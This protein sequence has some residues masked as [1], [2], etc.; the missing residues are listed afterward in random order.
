[1]NINNNIKDRST[2]LFIRK[3][4]KLRIKRVEVLEDINFLTRCLKKNVI[5]KFVNIKSSVH[6]SRSSRAL[7]TAKRQWIK[8]ELKTK[9]GMLDKINWK[10]YNDH[11]ELYSIY[12]PCSYL[13]DIELAKIEEICNVIKKEKKRKLKNKFE[14]L[15]RRREELHKDQNPGVENINIVHNLSKVFFSKE[16]LELLNKGLKHKTVPKKPPLDEIIVNIE[17]G[18]ERFE[19]GKEE[20]AAI[21]SEIREVIKSY[22]IPYKNDGDMKVIKELQEKGKEVYYT[23]PDKGKGVVIMDKEDYEKKMNIAL[24][25]GPYELT[26]DGRWKD[27]S[28]LSKLQND[29]QKTLKRIVEEHNFNKFI[30]S[31]LLVSNPKLPIVYGCPKIHKQGYPMRI[32]CSS[33]NEP[34]S[35]IGEYLIKELN[36]F[37][38]R[39]VFS[40]QNSQQFVERIVNQKILEDEVMISFDVV[41][42]FPSIPKEVIKEQMIQF[43][44]Q[45]ELEE[46][47]K[48]TLIELLLLCLRQNYFGFRNKIFRQVDGLAIGNKLS[49]LL[50]EIFMMNLEKSIKEMDWF[51]RIWIRYVDDIFAVIKKKDLEKIFDNLNNINANIRFTY[52]IESESTIPFLDL[53]IKRE[54]ENIKFSIYRK[55]TDTLRYITNDSFHSVQ[56][57]HAA[58]NF[59]IHRLTTI[60]MDKEDFEKEWK[61]ILKTARINGYKEKL[62]EDMLYN[63]TLKIA[64][65]NISSL[66]NQVSEEKN[67]ISVPFYPPITNK[68]KGIL[69]KKGIQ[70]SFSNRGKLQEQLGSTKDKVDNKKKSGIYLIECA[71][72]DCQMVY[73]GQTKRTLQQREIEHKNL[74]SK[75][76]VANHKLEE[77]HAM[78]DIKLLREVNRS[79]H[80]DA[81]ESFYL[82]KYRHRQ[83]MNENRF[84]N[85]MSSLYGFG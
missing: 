61:M 68:L 66:N 79:D 32:I 21:R 34:I 15:I 62:L 6:N 41:S 20:R 13:L 81:W 74:N 53:L 18:L 38:F 5:P 72:V 10:L 31:S 33:L 73:I 42:L 70:L 78:K 22:K 65:E 8:L 17:S 64:R 14:G 55:P 58:F 77:F 16:Q 80:L 30:A 45:Q 2:I 51:P 26:N 19:V 9:Y 85:L 75:S 71:N 29:V 3:F 76:A 57:K 67:Y 28:P 23:R 84:G 50:S 83:L 49:P 60:P 35:K 54:K 37:Q 56:N 46:N 11:Q 82:H 52:E 44:N 24:E 36:K 1:M 40:I 43:I 39:S 63:K 7:E 12:Y 48:K 47:K 69:R 27:N 25:K 59:L 4:K